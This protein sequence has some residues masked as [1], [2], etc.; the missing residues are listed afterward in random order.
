MFSK[1]DYYQI[2]MKEGDIRNSNFKIKY[3]LFEWLVMLFSLTIANNNLMRLMKHILCAFISSFVI[4]Y[5]DD[6]HTK[7]LGDDIEH[8]QFLFNM[9]QNKLLCA[10]L[11]NWK[12]IFFI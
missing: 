11:L 7:N 4:N 10:N 9:L 6:I 3:I 5:F 12:K 1:I 8:L 2:K